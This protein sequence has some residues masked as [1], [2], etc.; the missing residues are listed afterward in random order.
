MLKWTPFVLMIAFTATPAFAGVIPY[1]NTG[2]EAP[3]NNITATATGDVTGY[4]VEGG[5]ASGGGAA[6]LDEIR[7]FDVTTGYTS[8]YFFNNQTSLAG[9]TVDFGSVNAGDELVFELD[10]IS[11][12][13]VLASNAAYSFDGYNYG[14]TTSFS[15]GT[16]NGASIPAGTYVGM[17][18]SAFT[19]GTDFNYR[20]DTFVFTNVSSTPAVPEPASLVLL[21][22]GLMG[23][24]G[25]V[26]R[27]VNRA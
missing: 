8:A 15:G 11:A 27:R 16:L 18:D 7:L 9:D 1:P 14:Y 4:F 10:N 22:T 25:A 23:A 17:E 21:G 2:T 13:Y 26:R 24:V 5:F 12:G 6:D 20:D 19:K 3:Q